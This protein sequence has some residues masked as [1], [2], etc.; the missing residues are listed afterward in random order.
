MEII[1]ILSIFGFCSFIVS[2]VWGRLEGPSTA[3]GRTIRIWIDPF[4]RAP[5]GWTRAR[6][7]E[8]AIH[9]LKTCEVP[10]ISFGDSPH[11]D[12]DMGGRVMDYLEDRAENGN[13]VPTLIQIHAEDERVLSR[14]D[15]A[16]VRVRTL[17][18]EKRGMVYFHVDR[19][20]HGG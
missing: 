20:V 8:E 6:T 18:M 16:R 15:T 2:Y 11:T 13:T 17:E 10:A 14:L 7:P 19:R 4:K 1:A 9:I 3:P 5:R 12:R